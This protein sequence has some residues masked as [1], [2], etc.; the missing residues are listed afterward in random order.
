MALTTYAGL[1]A[2]IAAFLNRSDLAPMIPD[3]VALAEA[4]L[5]RQV[6]H[7]QM[8]KRKTTLLPAGSYRLAQPADWVEAINFQATGGAGPYRLRYASPADID[9][10]RQDAASG[11]PQVYSFV[12]NEVEVAPTPASDIAVEQIYFGA[13][14]ALSD[15][16]P[17]NWLLLAHPDA[18]LYGAL[19]HAAPYLD[20]DA[21]IAVWL[22][23]YSRAVQ[24]ANETSK[25]SASSGGVLLRRVRSFG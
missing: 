14:P 9:A 24:G 25:R 23:G 5:N 13:T 17:S 1:C 16:A 11:E 20:D 21:R 22:A 7:Q 19:T 3:F 2:S 15:A 8:V 6:R 10:V 12:G 18:Y 4:D